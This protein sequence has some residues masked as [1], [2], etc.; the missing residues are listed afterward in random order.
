MVEENKYLYKELTYEILG[1]AYD[2]FKTVG[3]GFSEIIYHKVFHERLM[4]TGLKAQ[5]KVP[6]YLDYRSQRIADFE[7]D[8]IVEDKIIVELKDIQC[9]FIPENYAQ[10]ITY[11]K[12]AKLRLGL[13]INFG[14]HKAFPKRI[15]F[16][17]RRE[18]DL[19]NW[20]TGFFDDSSKQSIIE[21]VLASIRNV[22][23]DLGAGYHSNNYKAALRIELKENQICY[24][25]E[26][27]F[28]FRFENMTLYPFSIDQW[29]VENSIL[30][31]VLAGKSGPRRFDLL[32]TRS[33]LKHLNLHHGLIVYWSPTNLQLFGIY[34]S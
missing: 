17:D 29:L 28:D 4:K 34:E 6:A 14:L 15:I 20:D 18:K 11:L 22:D 24:Q 8:E 13:L 9:D 21:T 32:R 12:V 2:A 3:V 25:E 5:Y 23:K 19:E 1:C 16:D 30:L 27:Q 7:I 31:C 26:V 10:I 33:Y